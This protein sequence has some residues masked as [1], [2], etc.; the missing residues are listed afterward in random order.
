MYCN[1]L[2]VQGNVSGIMT[3]LL[4]AL[5][6]SLQDPQVPEGSTI[7]KA[8]DSTF[9]MFACLDDRGRLYVTESSGGDLYE[10]LKKQVR[11][12]NVRRFEDRD[13][14]GV[15][16]SS[17]IVADQLTPSMG[18]AWRDGKLYVA[19]PP[20]VVV[21]EDGKRRVLLHGFGAL[22]NGSL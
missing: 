14:D 12:C 6:L 8:A 7:R 19:D 21:F 17:E 10:E 1:T 9:P 4:A 13:G 20:D 16:E 2:A 22:D 15:F 5:L 3:T 11:G 18:I